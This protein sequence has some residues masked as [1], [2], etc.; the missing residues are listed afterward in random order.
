MMAI[1]VLAI[2]ALMLALSPISAYALDTAKC[3]ARP[4]G[5]TGSEVYGGSETRLTWEGQ[6]AADEAIT[7]IS[8]TFPAGTTFGTDDA[9]LTALSGKDL[10]DRANIGASFSSDGET[11]IATFD[12]PVV[13]GS[14]IRLEVYEVIFPTTGGQMELHGTYTLA[15]D[16][17]IPVEDIT[18]IEVEG[19]SVTSQITSSLEEQDWVKSW[20]SNKFLRL[21]FNPVIIIE[22][23]PIVFQGFLMAVGIVA[24]A[25]PVAI[26]LGLCLS[27]MRMARLRILR[28]LASIY[29][30]VVRGTP[31]FLQI[32]IAFFGLPLA[33]IQIPSFPL[34]SCGLFF[35]PHLP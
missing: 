2:S 26:P 6:A 9:K 31:L 8:I 28:G 1:L 30:N 24:V 3:S 29:V 4:N 22:S 21:F 5:S 13:A 14:Y 34:L 11:L 7:G 20:N 25:F 23:F 16:T 12:E 10:M 32:Y 15:D 35:L 33:G 27:L 19:V 18:P 17:S